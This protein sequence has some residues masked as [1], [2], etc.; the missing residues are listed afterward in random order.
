VIDVPD[1]TVASVQ[2]PLL[3]PTS[4]VT[5]ALHMQ[6]ASNKLREQRQDRPEV[7]TVYR[8]LQ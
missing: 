5:G 1:C 6:K 7:G 2:A 8:E 3:V 4:T